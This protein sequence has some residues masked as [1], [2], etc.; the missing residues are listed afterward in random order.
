[1]L[2]Q[3]SNLSTLSESSPL[4]GLKTVLSHKILKSIP[5]K[6]VCYALVDIVPTKNLSTSRL[7]LNLCF[8]LDKSTSMQGL[9]LQQV[10]EATRQIIDQLEPNDVFSLI[11]FSDRSEVLIPAQ[12]GMNKALAKSIISTIQP[13]GGTEMFQG[14]LA[15]LQEIQ[16][17]RSDQVVN[18]I[19]LLTDGQT[20]GDEEDCRHQAEWAGQ[21]QIGISTTGIG[22]DWNEDLLD[23]ISN[24][25]GGLSS[26]IDSPR[27]IV[28]VFNS[29]IRELSTIMAREVTLQIKPA[30][31]IDLHKV[32]QITPYIRP[33][34][35]TDTQLNLGPLGT[36]NQKSIVLEFHIAA[37]PQLGEIS[38]ANLMAK[39]DIPNTS[40][41]QTQ[42]QAQV[43]AIVHT[44][45]DFV[46]KVP[47]LLITALG[48]LAVFQMQEKALTDIEEGN[49]DLATQR[50]ETVANRLLNLGETEL[51]RTALLEAGRLSRTGDLSSEG[52]KRIRYG[53][54]SLSILSED[55]S[56]D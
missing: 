47:S 52:R 42:V 8:I 37:S 43:T 56:N 7:P 9:R 18:H 29:A 10:K 12:K 39:G 40:I 11:I 55:L 53:T 45:K 38:L 25:S 17:H 36:N 30:P 49:I 24:A 35:A 16:K 31:N 51:A 21:N 28:S 14:L 13:S 1:M 2:G 5:E 19:L 50:L 54:R 22:T 46:V 27:K 33:L 15:G 3:P 48:K 4:L 20:Y 6:Q 26:Y 34:E 23:E 32:Y 41:F 44:E